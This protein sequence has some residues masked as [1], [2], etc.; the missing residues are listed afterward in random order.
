MDKTKLNFLETK[1]ILT[2]KEVEHI[3]FEILSNNFPWY[4]EAV[5]TTDKFQF[6][7]HTLLVRESGEVN[8]THFEFFE[9]IFDRFVDIHKLKVKGITRAVLNLTNS[10]SYKNGDPHVDHEFK[11][12]VLMLYLN[13]VEGNTIVYDKKYVNKKQFT[14]LPLEKIK[15]PLKKIKE[16][17]PEC[18]KA[19][20]WNGGYYHAAG[21]P[22]EGR[23]VVAVITFV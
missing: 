3:N 16:I 10:G 22:K 14:T 2:D 13:T 5:A 23:R 8:S 21:F 1:N 6:F 19:V 15:K 11:H 4:Y 20:C 18:G 12:K 7:S 9:N 17:K